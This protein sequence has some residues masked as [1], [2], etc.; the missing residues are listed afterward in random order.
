MNITNDRESMIFRLEDKGKV[1]YTVGISNKKADGTY[2]NAFFPIQFNKEVSIEDKTK[3]IIKKAWLSFYSWTYQ[4][5][6]GTSFF[7]RC[8]DFFATNGVVQEQPKED[9]Q[10]DPF[11]SF[12][13]SNQEELDNL[14]F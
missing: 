12:A 2:E 8:S 9:N 10:S 1:K 6:K 4:D 5:K 3:I 13:E 11:S 14:P 7:I